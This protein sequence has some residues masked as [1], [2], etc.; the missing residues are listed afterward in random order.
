VKEKSISFVIMVLITIT[1]CKEEHI[2][3]SDTPMSPQFEFILHDNLEESITEPILQKL[4]M[5]YERILADLKVNSVSKIQIAIWATSSSFENAME[6]DLGTRFYGATGY[7]Y[8]ITEI[9][10][11]NAPDAAQI[12]LHEFAHIVSMYINHS[13]PNNPRWLWEAVAIYESGE[14]VDPKNLDYML[15]GNYPTISELNTTYNQSNYRIYS[16]G[17]ILLEFI[18]E[19]WGMDKV[20]ELVKTNGELQSTLGLSVNEFE[21]SWHIF[22]KE[23]Y[24]E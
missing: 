1:S 9:R 21:E 15:R 20:I 10:I 4:E 17:Y 8:N 19:R 16:V 24:F 6:R 12:A 2:I 7:I 14:F 23:K 3:T 11:L 5:N 13:I 22:I 18:I